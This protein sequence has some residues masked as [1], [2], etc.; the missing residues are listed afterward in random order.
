MSI[1]VTPATFPDKLL[2]ILSVNFEHL[3]YFRL[4]PDTSA[5]LTDNFWPRLH[6]FRSTLASFASFSINYVT[7]P[8]Y[9]HFC[10]RN[11]SGRLPTTSK[12]FSVNFRAFQNHF[13]LIY[14]HFRIIFDRLPANFAILLINCGTFGAPWFNIFPVNFRNISYWLLAIFV[15]FPVDESTLPQLLGL[16]S[17]ISS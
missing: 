2:F 17:T 10:F 16:T 8:A 15:S 3:Q 1:T 12:P 5:Q 14:G 4:T 11:I 7:L 9:C 13:R 6:Y